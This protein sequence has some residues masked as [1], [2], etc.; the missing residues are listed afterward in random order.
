M[1]QTSNSSPAPLSTATVLLCPERC[2][3]LYLGTFATS[4]GA[5][6]PPADA[7]AGD[8]ARYRFFCSSCCV[9]MVLLVWPFSFIFLAAAASCVVDHTLVDASAVAARL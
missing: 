3:P 8:S 7:A 2:I 1:L 5:L 4:S 6:P 9:A